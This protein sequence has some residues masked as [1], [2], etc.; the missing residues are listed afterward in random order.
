MFRRHLTGGELVDGE[1]VKGA[2]NRCPN[3]TQL[4]RSS[5]IN[6]APVNKVHMKTVDRRTVLEAR[7]VLIILLFD[8]LFFKLVLCVCAF[9]CVLDVVSMHGIFEKLLSPD[10]SVQLSHAIL[11]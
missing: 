11:P 4:P 8:S 9:V 3:L 2:T 10:K 5:S 6:V 7:S 1:V